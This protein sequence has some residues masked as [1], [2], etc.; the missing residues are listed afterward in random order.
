MAGMGVSVPSTATDLTIEHYLRPEVKDISY[1]YAL[2]QDGSWRALNSDFSRWYK[3]YENGEARLLNAAEDYDG[4]SNDCKTLYQ[5]LNVFKPMYMATDAIEDGLEGEFHCLR[6][7]LNVRYKN[8][9]MLTQ[10]EDTHTKSKVWKVIK[11]ENR[12]IA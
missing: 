10:E 6:K 9:L 8:G 4:L 5:I 11:P 3:Y 7:K 1:N 2:L 12:I